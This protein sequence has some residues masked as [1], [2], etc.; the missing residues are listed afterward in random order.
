MKSSWAIASL[1]IL[2]MGSVI[3]C[4]DNRVY[5]QY[6]H[7]PVNG[8][9]KN[10]TLVFNLRR[11]AI[12]GEYASQ[13][14]VRITND[15]P[16]MGVTL[17]VEQTV[18]P[19]LRHYVDTLNCKLIDVK[20][21]STGIGLSYHQYAFPITTFALNTADSVVVQV[22]HDMKREILPGSSDIGYQL[23]RNQ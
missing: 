23:R 15:Y 22:R 18:Y 7:T 14:G 13:L 2:M 17:I 12:A 1:A 11:M 19:S 6:V 21:N 10:D 4:T 16:F 20:G 3:A 9:E 8:W 5:D